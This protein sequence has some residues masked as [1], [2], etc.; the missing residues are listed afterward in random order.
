[1]LELHQRQTL[2][3]AITMRKTKNPDKVKLSHYVNQMNYFK[4]YLG[5][6]FEKVTFEYTA[7]LHMH[8]VIIIPKNT[9]L[10]RFRVRG[11][12]IRLDEIYD[13]NGWIQYIN[14]DQNSDADTDLE[15]TPVEERFAMPKI[16]LFGNI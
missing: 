3:Y 9:S 14:K 8:G 2:A 15:D 10:V 12:S 16:K 6:Y 4:A 11:W 13:Y 1:M 5:C 7:G